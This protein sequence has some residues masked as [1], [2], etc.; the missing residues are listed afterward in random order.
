MKQTQMSPLLIRITESSKVINRKGLTCD[1][2]EEEEAGVRESRK[3]VNLY[4]HK[5]L[6]KSFP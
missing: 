6:S 1:A 4:Y 5:L 3:E 2:E